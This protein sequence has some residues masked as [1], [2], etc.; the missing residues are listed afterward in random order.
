MRTRMVSTVAGR[1]LQDSV[2]HVS[3]SVPSRNQDLN[4][5]VPLDM[6]SSSNEEM[7]SLDLRNSSFSKQDFSNPTISKTLDKRDAM[8]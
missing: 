4:P 3:T 1:S 7:S 2:L 8:L 6:A 5:L